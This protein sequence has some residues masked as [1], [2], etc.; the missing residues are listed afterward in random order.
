MI[1]PAAM[2]YTLRT[3]FVVL[4][5]VAGSV[6]VDLAPTGASVAA[7][8]SSSTIIGVSWHVKP[9]LAKSIEQSKFSRR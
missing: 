3:V 7:T 4:V 1:S 9:S 5:G 6:S 2:R 8:R